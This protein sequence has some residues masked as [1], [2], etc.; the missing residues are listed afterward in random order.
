MMIRKILAGYKPGFIHTSFMMLFLVLTFFSSQS[1]EKIPRLDFKQL[2]SYLHMD[3]DTT[4]VINFWATW[5]APCVKEMPYFE[6]LNNDMADRPVRVYLV[7]LDFPQHYESS[8]LPFV[9]KRK[10]K[11]RV[12]Y[13]DD[14]KANQWIPK[15]D[16]EWTGAIPATLI[17]RGTDRKFIEG[18]LTREELFKEVNEI[19]SY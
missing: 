19:M 18:S 11:S 15:I 3:N 5:C 10:I 14:G 16:S 8:L 7:S 17:Y 13:L 12:L 2:E 9:E 1:Q 6:D 4:Y